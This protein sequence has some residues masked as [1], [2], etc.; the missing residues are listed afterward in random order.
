[1]EYKCSFCGYTGHCYG[2]PFVGGDKS[3]V[4]AP[5]CYNCGLNNTLEKIK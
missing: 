5:W 4:S 1:M 2:T 3:G